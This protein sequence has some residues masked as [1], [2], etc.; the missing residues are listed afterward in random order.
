MVKTHSAAGR[1]LLMNLAN[2]NEVARAMVSERTRATLQQM[3]AQGVPLGPAPYGY[4]PSNQLADKGR[5]VLAPLA[6]IQEIIAWLTTAQAD[7]VGFSDIARQ[8][9]ADGIHARRGGERTGRFA[10]AVLQCEGKHKVP[11]RKPYPPRVPLLFDK[12]AAAARARCDGR[13]SS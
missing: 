3:K 13:R 2:Y 5:R 4:E 6:S 11:L 12:S 8:L 1:M 7:G 10:S 9:N